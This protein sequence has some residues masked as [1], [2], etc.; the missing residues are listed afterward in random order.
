[1]M[2][3]EHRIFRTFLTFSHVKSRREIYLPH[4]LQRRTVL[5]NAERTDG[6][7]DS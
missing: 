3:R 4:V 7:T 1:V 2:V 6:K 5:R